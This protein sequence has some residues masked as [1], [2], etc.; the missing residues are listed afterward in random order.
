MCGLWIVDCRVVQFFF[1][2]F[3]IFFSVFST[4]LCFVS[5]FSAWMCFLFFC[6][7]FFFSFFLYPGIGCVNL[8]L[9]CT[10]L[11]DCDLIEISRGVVM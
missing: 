4:W 3:I 8:I 10:G 5:A 2:F 11:I 7:G 9:E 6:F 1:F